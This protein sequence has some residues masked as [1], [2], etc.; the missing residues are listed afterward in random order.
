[1]HPPVHEPC[2]GGQAQAPHRPRCS[3][4][5]Q[6]SQSCSAGGPGRA[7]V[8]GCERNRSLKAGPS[9]HNW[10]SKSFEQDDHLQ[11]MLRRLE[12]NSETFCQEQVESSESTVG[13]SHAAEPSEVRQSKLSTLVLGL[14][15]PF[16]SIRE[17]VI[18][19]GDCPR[20]LQHPDGICILSQ[21]LDVVST[22]YS[23]FFF[24]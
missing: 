10:Y 16:L 23:R 22:T 9:W 15:S 5:A 7:M 21:S 18:R 19:A 17:V 14:C 20:S 24:V 12:S 4:L 3:G 2:H 11:I 13:T 8:E 1:M 6:Q